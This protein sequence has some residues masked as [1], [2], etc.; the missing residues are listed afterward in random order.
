[1]HYLATSDSASGDS[2]KVI[3]LHRRGTLGKSFL[4]FF[5]ARPLQR[6][7]ALF[8]NTAIQRFI[9]GQP[10][11]SCQLFS[12]TEETAGGAGT[13]GFPSFP[14]SEGTSPTGTANS[15]MEQSSTATS[16]EDSELTEA[17]SDFPKESSGT[18]VNAEVSGQPTGTVDVPGKTDDKT[19]TDIPTTIPGGISGDASATHTNPEA[20]EPPGSATVPGES[21]STDSPTGISEGTTTGVAEAGTTAPG[22]GSGDASD[23]SSSIGDSGPTGVAR[24]GTSNGGSAPSHEST[25]TS[26]SPDETASGPGTEQGQGTATQ[27][28]S[29]PGTDGAPTGSETSVS[30]PDQ[31]ATTAPANTIPD[32]QS[33][34]TQS[35]GDEFTS[36]AS[37][38]VT[39]AH[40]GAI[41]TEANDATTTLPKT[42]TRQLGLQR[43]RPL[44]LVTRTQQGLPMRHLQ[45]KRI[46]RS[47]APLMQTLLSQQ[48][49]ETIPPPILFLITPIHHLLDLLKP[50][51]VLLQQSQDSLRQQT[52][53]GS[54]QQQYLVHL[55]LSTQSPPLLHLPLVCQS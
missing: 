19:V 18:Q 45:A 1:M 42:K 33:T 6:S 16:P 47:S 29:A 15:P 20:S 30:G 46:S 48:P 50:T 40:S 5:S 51:T 31:P 21:Q 7:A 52:R 22:G 32:D 14:L 53:M 36:A 49:K 35:N 11:A 10:C 39:K 28:D 8:R 9:K 25:D 17:V 38:I 23:T 34:L 55:L 44:C 2:I 26:G 3:S 13:S 4:A 12:T 37:G 27:T 24:D 54:V 41:T 43:S